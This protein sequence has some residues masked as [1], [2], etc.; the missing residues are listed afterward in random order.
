MFFKPYTEKSILSHAAKRQFFAAIHV[1]LPWP[2]HIALHSRRWHWVRSEQPVLV[3]VSPHVIM[4]NHLCKLH[5]VQPLFERI[6]WQTAVAIM[7]ERVF[8][9]G[10]CTLTA[11]FLTNNTF[12][13]G[14]HF[15]QGDYV[16]W[17]PI[18]WMGCQTVWDWC[19][20]AV[21]QFARLLPHFH[22][23]QQPVLLL[24]RAGI[25]VTEP[26]QIQLKMC[27]VNYCY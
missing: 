15:R 9:D 21:H 6:L 10:C 26:V 1:M 25:F 16:F 23:H 7:A 3:S 22:H 11:T 4:L 12:T 8:G 20:G 19:A 24:A 13:R 18:R 14:A 2:C 17:L 5:K 27:T